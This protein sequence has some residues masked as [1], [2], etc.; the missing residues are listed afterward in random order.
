MPTPEE[1]EILEAQREKRGQLLSDWLAA[2]AQVAS[3]KPAI[4]KEMELR[5]AV[6]AE[7]F[8]LPKEGVNTFPLAEGWVL[9]GTYKIDRKVDVAAIPA[10]YAKL[11]EMGVNPDPLLEYKPSLVSSAYK[12]L[13][14]IN[15]EAAHVFDQ[16]LTIKPASPTVELKASKEAG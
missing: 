11:R 8:P 12:S 3:F 15:P 13:A 4:E 2:Q 6:M 16:A 14:T 7:F 1:T 10:V 9:K 5:K